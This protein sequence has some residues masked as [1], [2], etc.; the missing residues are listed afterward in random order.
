MAMI[1]LTKKKKKKK[2]NWGFQW[3]SQLSMAGITLAYRQT[4]YWVRSPEFYI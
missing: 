2:K 3:F 4:W 1:T